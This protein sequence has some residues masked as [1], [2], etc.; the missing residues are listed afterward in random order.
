MSARTVAYIIPAWHL[1]PM[2]KR[3]STDAE[4]TTYRYCTPEM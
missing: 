4:V 2:L 1:P 3:L